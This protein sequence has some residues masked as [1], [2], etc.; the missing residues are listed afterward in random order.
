MAKSNPELI[1]A[2]RKAADNLADGAR[3]EWGHMGRCNCGHLVQ[4]VTDLTATEIVRAVEFEMAEWTEHAED[5]CGGTGEKVQDLF[6]ALND[7]GFDHQ[8]VIALENLTDRRVLAR[9]QADRGSETPVYLRRNHAGDV[10]LYMETLADILEEG[11]VG[12]TV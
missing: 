6:V 5:Y 8:D 12:S 11:L 2:L 1:S 10:T 3:Y 9:I 4:T 7:V